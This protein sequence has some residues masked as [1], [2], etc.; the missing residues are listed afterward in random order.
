MPL[1]FPEDPLYQLLREEK[2]KAFNQQRGTDTVIDFHDCDFRGLDLRGLDA[3]G[4]DFSG[5]YFRA[6]DLRGIDFSQANL[7]GASV[8]SAQ[9]SGSLFPSNISANEILLSV[10]KGTRMRVR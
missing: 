4:I 3:H 10:E 1:R 9:I 2:V 7:S 5:C 6:A 8:A